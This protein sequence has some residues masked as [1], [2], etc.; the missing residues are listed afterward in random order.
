MY[1][2]TP[3]SPSASELESISRAAQLAAIALEQNAQGDALRLKEEQLRH[4]QKMEAVG[5]LAGGISHEFNNLLQVIRSYTEF[6]AESIETEHPA[7]KDLEFV[8]DASQRAMNLTRQ[9]LYFGRGQ[10]LERSTI[11]PNQ[12]IRELLQLLRPLIGENIDV[13]ATYGPI[14]RAVHIDADQFQQALMNLCINSRDAMPVGGTLSISTEQLTLSQE[15]CETHRH[16]KPG[17]TLLIAVTDTG[18]GMSQDVLARVFEPFFTTKEVGKGT[19][20]SMPMVYRMIQQH[21]GSVQVESKLGRGT[22]VRIYLPLVE[23]H[24]TAAHPL[25]PHHKPR[26][27]QT[28]LIAEDETL[29][30]NYAERVLQQA[31]YRTLR[32]Q[33]G[34]EAVEIFRGAPDK[35]ALVLLDV[36][37]PKL[38]GH[39][40]CEQIR[41]LNPDLPI[42]FCTGYDPESSLTGYVGQR[43]EIL[44]T[45][46]YSS[47][48]LLTTIGEALEAVTQL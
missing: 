14:Q 10:A 3:R 36:V 13:R 2:P 9:L 47:Q 21:D 45:K 15:F 5:A 40:V 20:L 31:G 7:R 42:V 46:P 32:A 8:M 23:H 37:M 28:I 24:A 39:Q 25:A 11:D 22:T 26:G 12:M 16:P 34:I 44:I 43:S 29:V 33:D 1:Y 48:D 35:V 38:N 19:G 18:I 30:A 17:D 4:A 27:N 41:A 6:V